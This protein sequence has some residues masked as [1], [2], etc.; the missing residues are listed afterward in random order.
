MKKENISIALETIGLAYGALNPISN[1]HLPT[2]PFKDNAETCYQ[3]VYYRTRTMRYIIGFLSFMFFW[4]ALGFQL[5]GMI[6]V[7]ILVSLIALAFVVATWK[8]GSDKND[9]EMANVWKPYRKFLK[10][11]LRAVNGDYKE[12]SGGYMPTAD[13]SEASILLTESMNQVQVIVSDI[14]AN[15][16]DEKVEVQYRSGVRNHPKLDADKACLSQLVDRLG[17]IIHWDHHFSTATER[18]AKTKRIVLN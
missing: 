7:A 14:A 13:E 4:A 11:R 2:L 16:A 17:I 5:R 10:T 9:V 18:L 1:E 12:R 15:I 6:I 3:N 8:I